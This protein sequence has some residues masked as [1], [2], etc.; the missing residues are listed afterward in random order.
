MSTF[1]EEIRE[2]YKGMLTVRFKGCRLFYLWM[3]LLTLLVVIG[4]VTFFYQYKLG[5]KLT[6]MREQVSWGFYISNFTFLVGVAAAAVLLIIPAYIYHFKSIKKIV[7]FGELMA[8]TAV[9]MAMLFV[10]VDLGRP[11]RIWHIIP[12]AGSPNL[13]RSIL[14]WDFVVLNGYLALNIFAVSYIGCKRYFGE[15]PKKR[16]I[17]PLVIV[18]I[19]WAIAVHTV[20]AFVYNGMGARAFWNASILAPRFLASAFC[21]GPALMIIVFQILRK[22][23]NFE[24]QNKAIFKIAEIIA[25]AMGINLFLMLAEI[26]K[27]YYTAAEHLAPMRY[28]FFGFH[29]HNKLVPWIWTAVVFNV[30]GFFIFLIPRTRKNFITLNIGCVLIFIGVWIEKGM[31]LILPGFIPDALGE[32]YEYM[33][34]GAEILIS[35]GIVGVGGIMYTLMVK[36]AVALETGLLRHPKARAIVHEETEG[37]V[38]KD[39]MTSPVVL[40]Y[41]D[42]PIEELGKLLVK[43]KI[44]GLPVVNKEGRIVGVVSER[45]IIYNEMKEVPEVME[46]LSDIILLSEY[47]RISKGTKAADIMTSPAITARVD[48]PVVKIIEE[49]AERNI[50]RIIVV[51]DNDKPVGVI[52]RIDIVKAIEGGSF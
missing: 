7:V 15:P 17:I 1:V 2:F 27:E 47:E 39:I 32:I 28:L 24:I 4:V 33:P 30:I 9:I 50:R 41:E 35:L 3:T 37:P 26:Y 43:N 16:V 6:N 46:R 45:D 51:D 36:T 29:G 44:S 25:Y 20:T 13:P 12:F 14:A 38:A 11:E 22:I 21:S 42:T 18:S 52:S 23:M 40:A 49:I 48:T 5:L 19:P 8:I 34:S 31:G 10:F